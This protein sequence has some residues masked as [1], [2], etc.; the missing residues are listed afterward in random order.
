MSERL[1][2]LDAL[3]SLRT[4]RVSP[5]MKPLV[6]LA[7][8]TAMRRGE[9]LALRWQIDLD[10]RV[11]HLS[12]TKNGEARS[13]PL[14]S[15]AMGIL[16][17]LTKSPC[18]SVFPSKPQT[19]AAAFMKAAKRAALIALRFHDLRHVATTS[20]AKRLPNVI[21]LAAVI[22]H[23]S[24]HMLKRYYQPDAADLARKLG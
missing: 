22:G 2:L 1:R 12:V 23:K 13:V 24:L 7:L 10:R 19:V 4:R 20:L 3:T 6:E 18:G 16:Q 17:G 5:W 21:E 8:E 11:A 15:A 9:L 14:S